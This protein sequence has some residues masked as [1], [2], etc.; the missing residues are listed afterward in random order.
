[1]SA[2]GTVTAI[3]PISEGPVPTIESY[4]IPPLGYRIVVAA[5]RLVPLV[6]A[7]IGLPVAALTFLQSHSIALPISID[8]LMFYAI[9]ICAISTARY[10]AKPTPWY[11][12][13]SL[14]SA[15]VTLA[16]LLTLLL[17]AT[18]QFGVPQTSASISVTYRDLIE[19][20]LVIPILSLAASLVTTLEDSRSPSE[21]LPYDF[22][23]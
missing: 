4:R 21:R 2:A 14:A 5:V 16:F 12:P 6:V 17:Q 19:V 13:I 18:Y 15:A 8:T 1:M 20:L 3:P 9:A 10:I 22:P 23:P 11:G 7:L